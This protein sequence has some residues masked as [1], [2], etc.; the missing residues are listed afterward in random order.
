[1]V[2]KALGPVALGAAV[3]ALALGVAT[4]TPASAMSHGEVK[5]LNIITSNSVSCGNYPQ[6]VGREL[7]IDGQTVLVTEP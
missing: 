6:F 2:A 1:M 4:A 5:E 7:G 3:G